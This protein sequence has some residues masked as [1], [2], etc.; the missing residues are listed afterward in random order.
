M[1]EARDDIL[2]RMLSTI[3]VS[4]LPEPLRQDLAAALRD[5]YA[6]RPN[7]VNRLSAPM[8]RAL[9]NPTFPAIWRKAIAD[10]PGSELYHPLR[11]AAEAI[12]EH[13]QEA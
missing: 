13:V 3:E 6:A 2:S 4:P 5:L 11:K 9:R 1:T 12:A 8:G 7:A 10:I